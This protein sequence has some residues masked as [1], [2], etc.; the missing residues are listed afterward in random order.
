M[1]NVCVFCA[2]PCLLLLLSP[3]HPS[4][5]GNQHTLAQL[6]QERIDYFDNYSL[7][8]L[9]QNEVIPEA[10]EEPEHSCDTTSSS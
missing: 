8:D 10:E 2:D 4:T 9:L 3:L 6:E 1:L 7:S 5:I